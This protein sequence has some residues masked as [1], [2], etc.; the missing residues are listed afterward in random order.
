[1]PEDQRGPAD[2]K[3][4]DWNG[5]GSSRDDQRPGRIRA[6]AGTIS[7]FTHFTHDLN[8]L[9]RTLN[10]PVCCVEMR[11]WKDFDSTTTYFFDRSHSVTI[12]VK[13]L[14][15]TDTVYCMIIH[16]R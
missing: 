12:L 9:Y 13:H 3:L 14:S 8:F 6:I 11:L 5:L 16:D 7:S 1:V 10:D 2:S 15:S 4:L